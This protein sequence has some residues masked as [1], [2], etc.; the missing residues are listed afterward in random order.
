MKILHVGDK[1]GVSYTYTKFLRLRGH[2]CMTIQMK[3]TDPFRF[4]NAYN[5][6]SKIVD[7]K[8]NEEWISEILKQAESVD[9]IHIH[10]AYEL[11]PHLKKYYPD[12]KLVLQYHGTD[13]REN[14]DS[15]ERHIYNGLADLVICST[16]DLLNYQKNMYYIPN[17][18]DTD[19]FKPIDVKKSEIKY[20][21][22][23]RQSDEIPILQRYLLRHNQLIEFA[24]LAAWENIK[25]QIEMPELL[26]KYEFYLDIKF[27]PYKNNPNEPFTVRSKAALEALA[28]G[29][30]VVNEKF[31]IIT[32]LPEEN[33]GMKATSYLVDF[34]TRIV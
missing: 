11:I 31:Q 4:S 16:K 23:G 17:P 34:Y 32:K 6:E 20:L 27:D 10:S 21:R 18:I 12:K 3:E 1:A 15:Q 2:E 8:T 26:N 29:L 25:P 33:D 24:F 28:C 13:L 19:R 14:S 9:I 22:I 30:K 7:P 5:V